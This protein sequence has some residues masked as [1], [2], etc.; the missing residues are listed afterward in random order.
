MERLSLLTGLICI[1][2]PYL[3]SQDRADL[4]YRQ[5]YFI[6]NKGQ[7]PAEVLYLCRLGRADIWITC[8]GLNIA[9]YQ[10]Y[11]K[12]EDTQEAMLWADNPKAPLREG[13]IIG[14]R[15]LLKYQNKNEYFTAEGVGK[16]PGYYNY[17]IG[18]DPR[19]HITGVGLYNEVW[20]R[21]IYPGIDIRYYFDEG[22][23]RYDWVV[24]PYADV[25]RIRFSI[26]G[27]ES[28]YQSDAN[29][30]TFYTRFG[31]VHLADMLAYQAGNIVP[32]RFVRRNENWELAVGPYYAASPLVIDPV[33]YSNLLAGGGWE[34]AQ[35]IAVDKNGS[36]YVV[37][38]TLSPDYDISSGAF[39]ASLNGKID[40]FITKT[41]ASGK[42][43][44]YSTFIGGKGTEIAYGVAVSKDGHPYIAGYTESR[45]FPA[46]LGS[47][48]AKYKGTKASP[49]EGFVIKLNQQGTSALYCTYLGGTLNDIIFDIALDAEENAYVVGY[50][51]SV[52]FPVS[53]KGFQKRNKGGKDAFI[54][55]IAP[56]GNSVIY[57]TYLGG[58]RTDVGL[59]VAVD[60]RGHAYITGYTE[61]FDLP[62][63][64]GALQRRHGNAADSS[65]ISRD[66]FVTKFDPTG[67]ALIYSTYIGTKDQ[68]IAA[69]IAVDASGSAYI[70]GTTNSQQFPVSKG[71]VQPT[72]RGKLD[73]FVLKLNNIGSTLLFSTYLGGEESDF[74]RDIKVDKKG[75]VY[76]VG[77]TKS[78]RF[79]VTLVSFQ[80][81]RQGESDAFLVRL[82]SKAK[83]IMYSTY[84][85]GSDAEE[86][87]SLDI[88]EEHKLFVTGFTLSD[89]YPVGR[90]REKAYS[91]GKD[92]FLT[93]L[94]TSFHFDD[95]DY[96]I[97]DEEGN[98]FFHQVC[99]DPVYS[100]EVIDRIIE[101]TE[102][103]RKM[104]TA[105]NKRG[106]VPLH[107]AAANH[108]PLLVRY[109]LD[110]KETDVDIKDFYG[111]T[112]LSLAMDSPTDSRGKYDVID[113]L[114]Q[115]GASTEYVF[116]LREE[117][118]KKALEE[119]KA[120]EEE[121]E[122][123]RQQF[124]YEQEKMA[125]IKK[126]QA[127]AG[128][129][130][131]QTRK[132]RTE[133]EAT[134]EQIREM[135]H[136]R[137]QERIQQLMENVNKS[138]QIMMGSD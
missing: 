69:G 12:K 90:G 36:T 39:Q 15:I 110:L 72:F 56:M 62:T 60:N 129:I 113:L 107:V 75:Y 78:D 46:T 81:E 4:A 22:H 135:R 19:S 79:P 108:N 17:L 1:V 99:A 44:I 92:V 25:S 83:K 85:G 59:A 5:P 8:Y 96:F 27:A 123:E 16:L 101:K 95:V 77:S 100:A 74:G 112:P 105:R 106:Q 116:S 80:R 28:I 9:F 132:T 58:S 40:A 13:E 38:W 49:Q 97:R 86:A 89:D 63:T 30:I 109:I 84:I 67:R 42:S 119:K 61:S 45:D 7:W 6:E 31:A 48:R 54:T 91:G 26:E 134:E 98:T 34:E 33:M 114:M 76:V 47:F 88:S 73:A 130:E 10:V 127:E 133:A 125:Y 51:E 50:T 43:L 111:D 52:R 65:F 14:Q 20:L 29:E 87:Y 124:L 136:R 104:L 21:G 138:L 131:A 115:A 37:G 3:Y 18:S 68:E 128:L 23:F 70:T 55:K 117:R 57:S 32:S 126:M 11:E 66:V 82:E 64:E 41:N 2:F 24:E 35:A 103:I 102:I 122:R 118:R 137:E 120:Q 71:V 121:A 93:H 53:K 94:S